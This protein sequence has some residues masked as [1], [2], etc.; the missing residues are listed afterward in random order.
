VKIKLDGKKITVDR[1]EAEG[2]LAQLLEQLGTGCVY[3]SCL[4][5]RRTR[6][7]CHGHYQEWRRLARTDEKRG[8]DRCM[9]DAELEDAGLLLPEGTGGG[10]KAGKSSA[11]LREVTA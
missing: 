1:A 9:T 10:S 8:T 4:N 2:I 7:L 6:G 5:T 3:P 11:F